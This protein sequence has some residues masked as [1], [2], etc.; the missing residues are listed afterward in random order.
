M[1]KYFYVLIRKFGYSISNESKR[2]KEI[3]EQIN[4]LGI[5]NDINDLLFRSIK[6]FIKIKDY[7][8]DTKIKSHKN[9]IIME[10]DSLKLYLESP[11]EFYIVNEVFVEKD[12]NFLSNCDVIVIDIGMNIGISSL[13]FALNKNV[14]KI[15]S[16]E[17]VLTTYNQAL[18]NLELNSKHSKKI[19]TYNFGIGGS[20]R[21]EKVLY[22]SNAKGNCGI[23]LTLSPSINMNNS[24]E[25]EIE[26][27]SIN[28]ILPE[29]LDKH[30]DKKIVLKIDCEGAEYEI[31]D[32]LSKENLIHKIDLILVEWHD[33]GAS[34]IEEILNKNNFILISRE[35]SPISGMIYAFKK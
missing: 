7:Y 2:K 10:F 11:E 4:F 13:F 14:E 21:I 17:P 30:L 19:K 15:Y 31:I 24:K 26:I 22:N 18:Y 27:K 23:R 35:L 28:E 29:I 8:P 34:T 32:K 1:K 33:K 20:S 9:G 3:K 12:Y 16:F 5:K 6:Y 25:I